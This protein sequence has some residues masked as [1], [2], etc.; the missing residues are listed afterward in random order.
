MLPHRPGDPGR[1]SRSPPARRT[2]GLLQLEQPLGLFTAAHRKAFR[3]E[4]AGLRQRRPLIPIDVFVRNPVTVEL[5]DDVR[6]FDEPAGRPDPGE[7]EPDLG[8]RG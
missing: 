1:S 8:C 7:H 6:K 2:G 3:I 5:D 4:E